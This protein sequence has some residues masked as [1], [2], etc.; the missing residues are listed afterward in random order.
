MTPQ[1]RRAL[2]LP[3]SDS[4]GT[5]TPTFV[6]GFPE[7]RCTA[8]GAVEVRGSPWVHG[9]S[10]ELYMYTDGGIMALPDVLKWFALFP[11]IERES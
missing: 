11:G 5:K 1:R 4:A 3:G 7:E 8:V 2:D 6:G 9:E 10:V